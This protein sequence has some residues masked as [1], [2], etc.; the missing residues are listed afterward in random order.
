MTVITTNIVCF[1]ML[2]LST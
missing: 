1:V 2:Q